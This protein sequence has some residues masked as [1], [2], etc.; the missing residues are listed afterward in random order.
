MIRIIL[1]FFFVIIFFNTSDIQAEKVEIINKI[2]TDVITNID[3]ENEYKYL[4]AL[5][6][7]YKSIEKKKNL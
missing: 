4:I 2:G 1:L 6:N 5:N 7:N 3:I